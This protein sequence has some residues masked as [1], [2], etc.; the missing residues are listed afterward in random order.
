MSGRVRLGVVGP[1]VGSLLDSSFRHGL[2]DSVAD[3]KNQQSGWDVQWSYT[4]LLAEEKKVRYAW[5]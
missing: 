5:R 1:H 3:P 2:I 4:L